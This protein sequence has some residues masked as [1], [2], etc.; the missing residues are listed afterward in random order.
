MIIQSILQ[1]EM[2]C[3]QACKLA[4]TVEEMTIGNGSDTSSTYSYFFF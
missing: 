4:T 2:Q 1:C 3:M